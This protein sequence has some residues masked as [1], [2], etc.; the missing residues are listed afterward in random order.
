[1]IDSTVNIGI[2]DTIGVINDIAEVLSCIRFTISEE[3]K[4][5]TTGS[6]SRK[7]CFFIINIKLYLIIMQGD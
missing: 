3:G 4:V 1:M 2:E 7:V 6:G 5:M